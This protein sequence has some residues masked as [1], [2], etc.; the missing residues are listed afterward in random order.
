[1]DVHVK[2]Y[3]IVHIR[4]CNFLYVNYTITKGVKTAKS[5]LRDSYSSPNVY[6]RKGSCQSND[7][8]FYFMK[9]E[10]EKIQFKLAG[11]KL[12]RKK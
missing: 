2:T 10:K 5:V 8:S 1:M 9:P 7:L 12:Q 3:Q 4:M 11:Q 6:I